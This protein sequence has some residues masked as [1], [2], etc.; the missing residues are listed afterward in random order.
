MYV[1]DLIITGDDNDYIQQLKQELDQEFTI[2]DLGAMR[3]FLGLEVSRTQ[4]GLLLNQRKYILDLLT[5][6]GLLDAK[7]F[8]CPFPKHVKLSTHEGEILD[9]AEKYRSLIGRL[10]YLNLSRPDISYSVQQLSQFMACPREPHWKAAL[11]L[12]R[13]LKGTSDMGLFYSRESTTSLTAYSD[14]DWGACDFSGRSLTGWCIF[15]GKSLVSWKTKKQKTVSKSSTE[16]EF[17]SM[18]QT[19]SEIVW[20]EGVLAALHCTIPKPIP[21]FCD[22]QAANHIAH[23]PVLHERTKHLKLDC[24]YVRENIEDG[25]ISTHHIKSSLQLADIMTKSLPEQQH[26]FLSLKLGLVPYTQVQLEG[27]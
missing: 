10:L 23:D 26:Q 20:V 25:F 22:N 3:Y 7:A 6:T 21:L 2:K 12:V 15:L 13:Y 1:D 24:F 19:T 18:S 27:G 11:H 9:D 14:A 17:R 5:H 16:S 8:K 4:H